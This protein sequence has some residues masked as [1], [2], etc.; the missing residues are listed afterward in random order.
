MATWIEDHLDDLVF[1]YAAEDD[2]SAEEWC[3]RAI[4]F[5]VRERYW[6]DNSIQES[7]RNLPTDCW[8]QGC[9]REFD[10]QGAHDLLAP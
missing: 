3:D 9:Q 4:L 10:H 2:C 6:L 1:K 8:Y 7:K 5:V